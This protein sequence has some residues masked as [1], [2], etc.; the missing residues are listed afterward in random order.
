VFSYNLPTMM[1]STSVAFLR[2][3]FQTSKV[4][5]V[6]EEL[7]MDVNEDI[8]AANITASIRPRNPKK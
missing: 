4:K 7:K 6:D 1:S 5:R 8:K 2:T 3:S